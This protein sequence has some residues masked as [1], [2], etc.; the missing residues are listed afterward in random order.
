[1]SADG[2]IFTAI[3]EGAALL[4]ALDENAPDFFDRLNR[5]REILAMLGGPAP[6]AVSL[7]DREGARASLARYMQT[8][9]ADL[10]PVLAALE[11]ETVAELA[12]MA[13]L[14]SI[15]QEAKNWAASTQSEFQAHTDTTKLAAF[16][17]FSARGIG[18]S[19]NTARL[20]DNV[21]DADKLLQ[22]SVRDDP[23]YT[24]SRER[25][26][27]VTRARIARIRELDMVIAEYKRQYDDL[28]NSRNVTEVDRNDA[29]VRLDRARRDREDYYNESDA[30]QTRAYEEMMAAA[31][32][33]DADKAAAHLALFEDNG[34]QILSKLA[35]ASPVT[36]EAAR[37]WAAEQVIDDNAKTKLKRLGYKPDDVVRD[38]A[39][40]YRLSG[41]KASTIRISAGGKRANAVGVDTRVGEKVINLGTY[42]NKTV[43]FH[44]L[45]HHLENDPI[46]KAASNGFLLKR[47]DDEKVYSLRDLTGIKAY[48]RDEV[49]WKDGFTDPYVGKVYR[50]G[51]TE[52]WS[53]GVQYLANPKDAAWFAGKDPEMFNLITGYL[54]AAATP[55]MRA[56]LNLHADAI[57]DKQDQAAAL[58]SQY[59]KALAY[60]ASKAPVTDDDWYSTFD[61]NTVQGE[62]VEYMLR[63]DKSKN[64]QYVGANGEYKVFSGTFRNKNTKRNA[65]GYL[66]LTIR[67]DDYP[68]Y[69]YVHGDMQLVRAVIAASR[70]NG[71][72][73][74]S[75]FYRY[76][77]DGLGSAADR[78]QK[79]I[80]LVGP[81][82][83]Q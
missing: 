62:Q 15:A 28:L 71:I 79:L 68:E 44:E 81:E 26:N 36:E 42:F 48:G 9:L 58:E 13:G 5:L 30:E 60:L 37:A 47:R 29:F 67:G 31:K 21:R 59:E 76:F 66:I 14:P 4:A 83:V 18:R 8:G 16:D 75:T 77:Y 38:M 52:V 11:A 50:G 10:P 53:M 54:S 80:D 64:P 43:L 82:N 22:T 45:A 63:R 35:E 51:I 40:Y 32:R 34:K 74:S 20:R 7:S 33:F 65:K 12:A 73:L 41:G 3:G 23:E 24:A 61:K 69:E 2:E 55:A 27:E 72:T 46:A 49:A 17:H 70:L 25:Y 19:M 1:M 78:Q 6:L 57:D 39:E 56:K